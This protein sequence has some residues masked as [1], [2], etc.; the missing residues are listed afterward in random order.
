MNAAAAFVTHRIAA[1]AALARSPLI[2]RRS[3]WYY[4]ARK[5]APHTIRALIADGEAVQIGNF[6]VRNIRDIGQ[7][8]MM[9]PHRSFEHLTDAGKSLLRRAVIAGE[10]TIENFIGNDG[11]VAPY[12]LVIGGFAIIRGFTIIP[13]ETAVLTVMSYTWQNLTDAQR[14]LL[15]EMAETRASLSRKYYRETLAAL[16]ELELMNPETTTITEFGIALAERYMES[17]T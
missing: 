13:N 3:G 15:F 2:W 8:G 16:I 4:K 6:V 12:E 1:K 9:A 11:N 14:R 10:L 17:K 5:F 7:P